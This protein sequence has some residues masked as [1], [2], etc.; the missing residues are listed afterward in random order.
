MERSSPFPPL[1]TVDKPAVKLLWLKSTIKFHEAN[2]A[3]GSRW[4]SHW[5]RQVKIALV[6]SILGGGQKNTLHLFHKLLQLWL[7]AAWCQFSW[8]TE[9]K[10]GRKQNTIVTVGGNYVCVCDVIWVW[11]CHC[12]NF[13]T[14]VL[15]RQTNWNQAMWNTFKLLWAGSEKNEGLRNWRCTH[16]IRGFSAL[17]CTQEEWLCWGT[18]L[19]KKISKRRRMGQ[20]RMMERRRSSDG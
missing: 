13:Q 16:F 2:K 14:L 1:T 17:E 5:Y 18:R 10:G 19:L 12:S 6:V 7:L 9:T 3:A 11:S 4:I 8:K 20:E 15:T